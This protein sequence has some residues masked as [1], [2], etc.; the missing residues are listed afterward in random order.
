MASLEEYLEQKSDEEL[1]GILRSYCLGISNLPV[2][3]AL[4]ICNILAS[5]DFQLPDPYSLFLSLCRK[6][7]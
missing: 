1:R 7:C 5:R 6:Y 3:T 4:R 2:D